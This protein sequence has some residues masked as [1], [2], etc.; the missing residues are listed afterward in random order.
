MFKLCVCPGDGIGPEVT[1]AAIAVFETLAN[2]AGI[3][4]EINEAL[5]GGAAIDATGQ[6]FPESAKVLALAS[7][8]V[9]LGAVGGDKW[10]EIPVALRPERGLL[11][12]RSALQ[13]YANLR[14][15]QMFAGLEDMSPLKADRMKNGIDMVIVRELTG[16]I[17]FGARQEG[18]DAASD[19][20]KYT[21]EEIT[22]IA[23]V[24]FQTAQSRDKRVTSVDKA[25]VL[26]SSRLWRRVMEEVARDYPDVVLDHLYV[27]NA[28]MQLIRDPGQFDVMVTNN[29]FGDILSDEASV[30][31]GSIGLLP[32]ASIG[33]SKALYEPIHGS[34]PDIA[35]QGKANPV[36]AILSIAMLYTHSLKR[37]DLAEQIEKAVSAVL[38]GGER[39]G[40]LMQPGCQMRTT[41][42]LTEAIVREITK[43]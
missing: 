11:A 37:K 19:E 20:E 42:Q 43:K 14:P 22:R 34:A 5:I 2:Q 6:P 8:A 31:V 38:E 18:D 40:D 21:R 17:Y 29:I 1:K 4:Y 36:A 12:L 28:A 27:D 35:G 15:V 7:D 33:E 24:A 23:H 26:A 30:L 3:D 13:T 32:S 9:F 39:T 10:N 16:G 25:N 41:E